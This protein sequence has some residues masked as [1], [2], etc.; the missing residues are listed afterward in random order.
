[1]AEDTQIKEVEGL[2]SPRK[3][4]A[5]GNG[6]LTLGSGIELQFPWV[7]YVCNITL[8]T[9]AEA[10]AHL[11]AAAHHVAVRSFLR[12]HRHT[13]AEQEPESIKLLEASLLKAPAS[14]AKGSLAAALA[15]ADRKVRWGPDPPEEASTPG[16]IARELID[17]GNE[18]TMA[19]RALGA[20][21]E[22]YRVGYLETLKWKGRYDQ[23]PIPG[24]CTLCDAELGNAK[25]CQSHCEGQ[26]HRKA[27]KAIGQ[28]MLA[29][30]KG[31]DPTQRSSTFK[32]EIGRSARLR[33]RP[34]EST[35]SSASSS[36][37]TPS[38]KL[39]K[40][41]SCAAYRCSGILRDVTRQA[42]GDYTGKC[43]V[44]RLIQ[45]VPKGSH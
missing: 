19:S 32:A 8:H 41:A 33:S 7:D 11:A 23:M 18:K 37:E 12:K 38:K 6:K 21:D 2:A 31:T 28:E 30:A 1:M 43:D 39:R 9:E 13:L 10:K 42:D 45:K 24:Y 5:K 15:G 3:P 34:R 20:E 29:E 36:Y 14:V 25:V 4:P 40:E 26:P 35:S 17:L 16:S 27:C 44:C 22:V